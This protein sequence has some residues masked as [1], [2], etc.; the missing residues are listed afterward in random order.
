M[1]EPYN[2]HTAGPLNSPAGKTTDLPG[3]GVEY[4]NTVNTTP[5]KN[6]SDGVHSSKYQRKPSAMSS[7]AVN[8]PIQPIHT[9]NSP[10][11]T[12]VR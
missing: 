2:H 10:T 8:A 7:T 12:R 6:T 9:G 11:K 1:A 4:K 3:P 5:K